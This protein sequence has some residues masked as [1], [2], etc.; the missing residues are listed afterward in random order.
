MMKQGAM[1]TV[2]SS[3]LSALALPTTLLTLT[4]IIDIKWS[5]AVDRFSFNFAILLFLNSKIQTRVPV[6]NFMMVLARSNA[7]NY[8]KIGFCFSPRSDNAEKLLAEVLVKGLQGTRHVTLIGF[9]LGAQ[10]IFKCLENLAECNHAGIVERVILLGAPIAIQDENWEA[11]RRVVL[12]RLINAYSVNDWMFGVAFCARGSFIHIS[13]SGEVRAYLVLSLSTR[14]RLLGIIFE[15]IR[16]NTNETRWKQK[17]QSR[18]CGILQDVEENKNWSK[19]DNDE[20]I[21]MNI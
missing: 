19:R 5:I 13:T 4:D 20:E 6:L 14:G 18:H 15:L 3:H 17:D 21:K 7:C 1:M 12:V 10:A 2:L 16:Q 9:S 11:A 8:F